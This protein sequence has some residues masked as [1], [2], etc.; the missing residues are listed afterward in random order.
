[1]DS[2]IDWG[3]DLKG[4]RVWMDGEGV[5]H[6]RLSWFGTARPEMYGIEYDLLPG[7]PY[8]FLLWDALPF[9]RTHPEPGVYVISV[10]NLVGVHF[11]DS[12]IYSWFRERPPDDR[13]GNSLFVY[14]VGVP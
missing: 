7:L 6:I 5:D 12:D 3:Q 2:N 11:P 8:G 9:D 10:T 14:R 4:L 13:I 1:V